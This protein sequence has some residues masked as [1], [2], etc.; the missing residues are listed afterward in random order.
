MVIL[1]FACIDN[2]KTSGVCIAALQHVIAQGLFSETALVNVNG[3]EISGAPRQ[4]VYRKPFDV[5]RL[6]KPFDRPDLA[7]FQECYRPAYL[8]IAD[9][10]RKNGIPYVIIPHGEL[11][12]EAQRKKHLKKA[13]ANFLLFN[14]FVSHAVAIQCLSQKELDSTAFETKKFVATNGVSVPERKKTV[15]SQSGAKIVFIGRLDAYHKGLDLMI[16]AASLSKAFLQENRCRIEIYG[17][18]Y[19]GRY[20][21]VERLIRENDVEDVVFLHHEVLGEEKIQKLLDS[22]LFIQT[23]RFE[24]MPLG[25]LEAMSYGLP[26]LVTEGTALGGEIAAARAGWV[27]KTDAEDIAG[28]LVDAVRDRSRWQEFGENGRKAVLE[29]YAWNVIAADTLKQYESILASGKK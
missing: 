7:V 11:G 22:D 3:I 26:C 17:P 4:L 29:R 25:I 16:R 9:N 6:P 28:H 14:D 12:A 13:L 27:A 2:S 1:H 10:L 8:K 20:E 5:R 15:F 19:A 21:N 24:G 23:S 18:D